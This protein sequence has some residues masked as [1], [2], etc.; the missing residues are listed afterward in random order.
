MVTTNT[1]PLALLIALVLSLFV[2]APEQASASSA[3]RLLPANADIVISID[4]TAFGNPDSLFS[5]VPF[6]EVQQR[7]KSQMEGYSLG[8]K[9]PSKNAAE[10]GF[11]MSLDPDF[12]KRFQRISVGLV[13]GAGY[14]PV[15]EYVVITGNFSTAQSAEVL[16]SFGAKKNDGE[17]FITLPSKSSKKVIYAQN[18]VQNLLI[19]TSDK[20]WLSQYSTISKN[21][22]GLT[23]GDST[24]Q[25]VFRTLNGS[26][27]DLLLYMNGE[28]LGQ[29]VSEDP[30]LNM[31]LG[32]YARSKGM[33]LSLQPGG[34][35][36]VELHSS[37]SS[38]SMATMAQKFLEQA[39]M[40]GQAQAT[41][42]L[43]NS[44]DPMQQQEAENLLQLL[45]SIAVGT[46]GNNSIAQLDIKEIPNK[47]EFQQGFLDAMTQSLSGNL[48]LDA[49][50]MIMGQ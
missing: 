12:S 2:T 4:Q 24:F 30:M 23:G 29:V 13:N 18:P 22:S 48:N 38:D 19:L 15:A 31:V 11:R 25:S 17:N 45:D 36:R 5:L 42:M 27:N 40:L 49:A 20:S 41:S 8:R 21:N 44:V 35:P 1:S 39:I 46:K 14:D 9:T 37:F 16:K 34:V 6:G 7:F 47:A 32:P 50:G 3:L 28:V 26:R 10:A 43:N 33:I